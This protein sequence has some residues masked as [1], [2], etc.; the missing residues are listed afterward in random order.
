MPLSRR[1]RGPSLW[2]LAA[3]LLLSLLPASGFARSI[4]V[5]SGDHPD[6]ARLVV[7]LSPLPEWELRETPPVLRLSLKADHRFEL[8]DVFRFI[9]RE[10]ISNVRQTAPGEL[11]IIMACECRV[12][13]FPVNAGLVVDVMDA[14]PTARRLSRNREPAAETEQWNPDP[15]VLVR[16]IARSH[17]VQ[18]PEG[19]DL[20]RWRETPAGTET[21]E[22]PMFASGNGS[23][24]GNPALA[25]MAEQARAELLRQLGR[26]ASQ[27]IIT[28]RLPPVREETGSAPVASPAIDTAVPPRRQSPPR[29]PAQDDAHAP[30]PSPSL[31]E[32]S[33]PNLR[34]QGVLD[35]WALSGDTPA[36]TTDE[37][38]PCTPPSLADVNAW[39]E[40]FVRPDLARHAAELFDDL[41]RPVP[42]AVL[43][44]ARYLVFL[45]FG[46]EAMATLDAFA[47]EETEAVAMVREMARAID[48][49]PGQPGAAFLRA[50]RSCPSRIALWAYLATPPGA[51]SDALDLRAVTAA[52]AELPPHLKRHLGP[53][54]A[55]RLLDE[56][57][58][59]AAAT[60]RAVYER[61]PGIPTAPMRLLAAT[62]S[63]SDPQA[64]AAELR[65]LRSGHGPEAA[66]A[67]LT[68][69][70]AETESG[71]QPS[72]KLLT[73]IATRAA[74]LRGTEL[75]DELERAH[76]RG[77]V[78]SGEFAAAA[79]LLLR[80]LSS[81]PNS[82]DRSPWEKLASEVIVS[83]LEVPGS[84]ALL[85]RLIRVARH[86]PDDAASRSAHL[87]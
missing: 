76:I 1:G 42:Q 74:E 61:A 19:P 37:G 62:A 65:A 75:G 17:V 67:L 52:V 86:L 55:G 8:K 82:F 46:A 45:G 69:F 53:I 43:A 54:V 24:Q 32:H 2:A 5:R 21:A 29:T 78:A 20:G 50:Q 4:L 85:P 44:R 47:L 71:E 70:L 36:A 63:P 7:M 57:R 6:F 64:A 72:A 11:E 33:P 59:N 51:A 77:L 9:T 56:G 81:P 40:E 79:D 83:A 22:N 3:L 60:I 30:P 12:R 49:M 87:A 68:L 80:M 39:G 27:G 41:D 16:A 18:T 38:S 34:V 73:D 31:A 26:S 25:E 84:T 58:A 14:P 13:A 15:L 10:R 23:V 66:R 35:E 28:L 48:E